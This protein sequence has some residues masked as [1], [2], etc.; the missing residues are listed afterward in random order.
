MDN[1]CLDG[2][3]TLVRCRPLAE[4]RAW[5]IGLVDPSGL[6]QYCRSAKGTVRIFNDIA[7][8]KLSGSSDFSVSGPG[9]A[10]T[11]NGNISA[12]YTHA[13]IELG[14]A[15][16]VFSSRHSEMAASTA[17]DVLAV[18]FHEVVGTLR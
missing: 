4:R 16:E 6:V 18:Y 5:C 12:K 17:F 15:Y 1:G 13:T 8:S 3:G 14:G 2:K 10:A 9:G 7:Y 11:L